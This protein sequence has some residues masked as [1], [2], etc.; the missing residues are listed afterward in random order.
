MCKMGFQPSIRIAQRTVTTQFIDDEGDSLFDQ[1]VT[2][3][4][5]WLDTQIQKSKYG[6]EIKEQ[7]SA[8]KSKSCGVIWKG[9]GNRFRDNKGK[10]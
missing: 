5:T 6:V 10:L 3:D 4:K 7:S 8:E 2:G 9:H 1:I